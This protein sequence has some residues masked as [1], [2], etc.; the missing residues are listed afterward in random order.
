MEHPYRADH[1]GS[2]LRPAEL[3]AAREAYA[4]GVIA[5]DQL[6]EAEDRAILGAIELQRSA[7]VDVYSDGEYRRGSFLIDTTRAIG[8][9][10]EVERRPRAWQGPDVQEHQEGTEQVVG[11]RVHRVGK[12]VGEEAAYLRRHAPGPYKVTMPSA[13]QLSST[14]YRE[15]VTDL[16]YPTRFDLAL[17]L[18]DLLRQE[19]Q[20]LIDDGVPYIQIDTPSYTQFCD[21]AYLARMRAEGHDPARL[22]DEWIAVDNRTLEGLRREGVTI[23][24]HLCR[25]NSRGRWMREGGYGPIAARLFSGVN[26]D[27]FLLEYDTERAGDFEPLRHVPRDKQVVLGL[28]TTKEGRLETEDELVQRLEE[29]A[30]Y[31]PLEN[32]AMSPQ[33]G[34][35]TNSLGNPITMDDQ[36]RKLDVLVQT[37]RRVWG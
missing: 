12:L 37:A 10:V 19:I 7:G 36:R 18:G 17:A 24:M 16:A 1:V 5:R 3:L 9:L 2:L 6:R 11:E 29:A 27:R 14:L 35:S 15:G 34:F 25:G 8:G 32:L 13:N 33:C 30:A 26:V 23:G 4:R 20:E 31:V 28:I 22:L 21:D